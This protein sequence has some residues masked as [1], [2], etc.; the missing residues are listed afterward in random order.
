MLSV[1]LQHL[2]GT[3]QLPGEYQIFNAIGGNYGVPSFFVL[4]A[5]LLTYK[6]FELMNKSNGSSKE[7]ALII[8]KYLIR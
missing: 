3:F 7:I 1:V 4:S 8:I 6:Q 2:A 5:F